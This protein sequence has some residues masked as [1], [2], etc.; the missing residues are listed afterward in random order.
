VALGGGVDVAAA[1]M[2]PA[3]V[4]DPDRGSTLMKEE[5]S[6]PAL[7]VFTVGSFEAALAY[8]RAGP[9]PLA[10]YLFTEDKREERQFLAE[11]VSGDAVINHTLL[12]LAVEGLPFGG[13]GGMGRYHGHRDFETFSKPKAILR[14]PALP[15]PR[16]IYPPYIGWKRTLSV[17]VT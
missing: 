10:S 9:R 6:Y 8:V 11:V 13:V 12:H 16:L 4:V 3:A 14:K 2:Q 17:P 5:I 7:P 1:Q 15:H